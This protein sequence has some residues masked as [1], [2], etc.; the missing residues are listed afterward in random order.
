MGGSKDI[1]NESI[2]FSEESRS[3]RKD[4]DSSKFALPEFKNRAL[5]EEALTHSSVSLNNNNERLE[6]LGDSVCGLAAA[7]YLF[8]KFPNIDQGELTRLKSSLVDKYELGKYCEMM[9]ADKDFQYDDGSCNIKKNPKLASDLFEAIIGAY[10]IDCDHKYENVSKFL[11]RFFDTVPEEQFKKRKLLDPKGE[12]QRWVQKHVGPYQPK[13][14]CVRDAYFE[15]RNSEKGKEVSG[16]TGRYT[17]RVSVNGMAYG[18]GC[19]RNKASAS[20][21]CAINA[22]KKLVKSGKYDLGYEQDR[23][24]KRHKL[25]NEQLEKQM[26][27]ASISMNSSRASSPS[28]AGKESPQ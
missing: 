24:N 2:V 7:E 16:A 13:Y 9:Q 18:E 11:F 3:Q 14:E 22:I 10:F 15:Q 6:F 12:F 5:L 25:I 23:K 21:E 19:G 26:S 17:F 8:K 28:L 4:I 1:V 20:K 27:S